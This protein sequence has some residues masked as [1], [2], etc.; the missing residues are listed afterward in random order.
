MPDTPEAVVVSVT[1]HLESLDMQLRARIDQHVAALQAAW[2]HC[3]FSVHG[4]RIAVG[5][6][7]RQ[8]AIALQWTD[9]PAKHDVMSHP[10]WVQMNRIAGC[11]RW[12]DITHRG[13]GLVRAAQLGQRPASQVRDAWSEQ[14]TATMTAVPAAPDTATEVFAQLLCDRF[15]RATLRKGCPNVPDETLIAV[16]E[17]LRAAALA[18]AH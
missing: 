8:D 10:D 5:S 11:G 17:E 15:A 1:A 16:V 13:A 18:L 3:R 7:G 2:P 9:G 4:A 14:L 12:R 6:Y